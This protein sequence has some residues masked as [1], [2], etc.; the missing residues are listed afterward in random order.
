MGVACYN[1]GAPRVGLEV[2]MDV[3]SSWR[4]MTAR[5]LVLDRMPY[6]VWYTA[7]GREWMFNRKYQVIAVRDGSEASEWPDRTLQVEGILTKATRYIYSG[8]SQPWRAK[9]RRNA[10]DN[11][12]RSA[13]LAVL[14]D[15]RLATEHLGK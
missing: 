9:Y 5:D 8:N 14:H 1:D 7:D 15:W 12:D 6:G 3:V 13:C 4:P 10:A 11:R 2:S